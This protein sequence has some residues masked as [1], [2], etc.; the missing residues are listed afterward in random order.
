MNRVI[1]IAI[2]GCGRVAGHHARSI[3][4][5]SDLAN[6]V[7]VCDLVEERA[8]DLGKQFNVPAY[9]NYYYLV[10]SNKISF[11]KERNSC[12]I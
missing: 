11:I 1:N 7:A 10:S 3:T 4:E 5:I 6:L 8:N 2:I 9:S 12:V